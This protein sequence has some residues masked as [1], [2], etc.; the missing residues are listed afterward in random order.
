MKTETERMLTGWLRH[1]DG[2]MTAYLAA[3]GVTAWALATRQAGVT[4]SALV[5][6]PV[7]PGLY[8]MWITRRIY[9]RCDEYVRLSVLQAAAWAAAVTAVWTLVYAF[10][11]IAGLPRISICWVLYVGWAVFVGLMLRFIATDR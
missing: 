5:L 8:I 4:R 3:L 1:F 7:L 10:L 9:L 2:A 11:E 6:A